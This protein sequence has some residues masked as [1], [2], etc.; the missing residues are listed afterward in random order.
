MS[1]VIATT[2]N[3]DNVLLADVLTEG[4]LDW[5]M[6]YFYAP[7]EMMVQFT[8]HSPGEFRLCTMVNG[9]GDAPIA[10]A[11]AQAVM[12]AIVRHFASLIGAGQIECSLSRSDT[13]MMVALGFSRPYNFQTIQIGVVQDGIIDPVAS[14]QALLALEARFGVHLAG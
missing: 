4:S 5:R 6:S 14:S 9:E 3:N 11:Q 2:T 8:Q 10:S 13:D 1:T 7:L 12:G